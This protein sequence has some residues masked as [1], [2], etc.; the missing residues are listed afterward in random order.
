[1]GKQDN[2]VFFRVKFKKEDRVTGASVILLEPMSSDNLS[3]Y[4]Y[5]IKLLSKDFV[6]REIS[7]DLHFVYEKEVKDFFLKHQETKVSQ[8]PTRLLFLHHAAE[9]FELTI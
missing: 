5:D 3:E 8:I 1:M 2:N 6:V 4:Q 9:E 7:E